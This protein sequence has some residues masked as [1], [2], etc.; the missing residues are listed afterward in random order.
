MACAHRNG[1]DAS[2]VVIT[3]RDDVAHQW[4]EQARGQRRAACRAREFTKE[5]SMWKEAERVNGDRRVAQSDNLAAAQCHLERICL[6]V[7]HPADR[8]PGEADTRCRDARAL[9]QSDARVGH[10]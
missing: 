4:Q 10:E 1:H 7:A 8:D 2:V 6:N 3:R 5:I 9:N